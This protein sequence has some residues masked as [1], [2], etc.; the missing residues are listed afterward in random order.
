MAEIKNPQTL[1]VYDDFTGIE[2]PMTGKEIRELNLVKPTKP[3]FKDPEFAKEAARR[4]A[5]V[6]GEKKLI[7]EEMRRLASERNKDGISRRTALAAKL[8]LNMEKSPQWYE[9]GLKLLGEMPAEKHEVVVDTPDSEATESMVE[10]FRK[11]VKERG[12]TDSL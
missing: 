10:E 11:R 3:N 1:T 6:R 4:S 9:L 5:E 2:R 12:G 8:L 7:A